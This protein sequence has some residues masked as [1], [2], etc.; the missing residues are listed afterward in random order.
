MVLPNYFP[1]ATDTC[2]I[3]YPDQRSIIEVRFSICPP[4]CGSRT[5]TSFDPKQRQQL[6]LMDNVA[7]GIGIPTHYMKLTAFMLL[8]Q[9]VCVCA[10]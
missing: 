10:R 9:G 2:V 7:V 8:H 6:Y 5:Y 3:W 4:R 1:Y